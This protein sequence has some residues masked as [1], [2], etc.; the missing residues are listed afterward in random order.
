MS[1]WRSQWVGFKKKHPEFEKNKQVKTDVGP[2]MDTYEAAIDEC[3][4]LQVA[5]Q[6]SMQELWKT[7]DEV[8]D[9]LK[10]YFPIVRQLESGGERGITKDFAEILAVGSKASDTTCAGAEHFFGQAIKD[11]GTAIKAT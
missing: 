7:G 9:A 5:L 6:K 10:K 1:T 2:K 3:R 11:Y 4:K 8:Q